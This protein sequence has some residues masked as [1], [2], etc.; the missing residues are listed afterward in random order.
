M[1]FN[2]PGRMKKA[3]YD[4]SFTPSCLAFQRFGF[5]VRGD[6]Q[7]SGA[8]DQLPQRG[9][10]CW[11]PMPKRSSIHAVEKIA[12]YVVLGK[13][14]TTGS[15]RSRAEGDGNVFFLCACLP[16]SGIPPRTAVYLPGRHT[17][18][19]FISEAVRL[20]GD[21]AGEG[22]AG[23]GRAICV[24]LNRATRSSKKHSDLSL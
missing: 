14:R 5:A 21:A 23:S 12:D 1:R 3:R 18:T 9:Q 16:L 13:V 4:R 10:Q 17:I 11:T 8:L 24:I 2:S 15:H 7:F 22:T 19:F 6:N 20:S